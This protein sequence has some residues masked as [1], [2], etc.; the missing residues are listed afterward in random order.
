MEQLPVSQ[1]TGRT[2]SHSKNVEHRFTRRKKE[3]AA[4]DAAE[5]GMTAWF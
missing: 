3:L 5:S 2:A 4:F 1:F